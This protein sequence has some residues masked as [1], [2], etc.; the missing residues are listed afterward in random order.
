LAQAL[1]FYSE[2]CLLFF[3]TVKCVPSSIT[4]MMQVL[5]I[6]SLAVVFPH[7]ATAHGAHHFLGTGGR[8]ITPPVDLLLEL[9]SAVGRD[10]RIA[11]ESRVSRLE[12]V[13]GP[14]FASMPKDRDRLDSTGVRYLLHRLFV[15]RHGW[16]IEGLSYNGEAWNSSSPATIFKEHAEDH[17]DLFHNQIKNQGGFSLHQVAVFGAT[18]EVMVHDENVER[19]RAAYYVLGLSPSESIGEDEAVEVIMSY[20]MMY[21]LSANHT[22]LTPTMF[23]RNVAGKIL[24]TY[25][26]WPDTQT[27]VHEVRRAVLED[28]VDDDRTTWVNNLKILEEIGERYGRWQDKDCRDLKQQMMQLESAGNGR[29]LLENLYRAWLNDAGEFSESVPYLRVSGSLDESDPQH[30]SVI[31]PNYLNSPANC[32]ASSKFHSVCC[33]SECEGL[34][35]NLE[36]TLASPDATPARIVELISAL[37]SDSVKA[38]RS[39]PPTLIQRLEEIA[40]HHGGRVPLHGRLFA[41]WMHHAYPHECP[42]P[43]MAGTSRLLTSEQAQKAGFIGDTTKKEARAFI[44]EAEYRKRT[45]ASITTRQTKQ[46]VHVEWHHEEELFVPQFKQTSGSSFAAAFVRGVVLVAV[47]FALVTSSLRMFP[48]TGAKGGCSSDHKYYV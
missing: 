22:S 35:A 48:H 25:P 18:L 12:D 29:V 38:P 8:N 36:N 4:R 37:P 15:Q 28:I 10:H 45:D 44:E 6:G 20:M 24:R 26:M 1:S 34:M 30:L 33:I 19:L 41:Q 14:M 39:L 32:L 2:V 47:L 31:I 11:T 17:H 27:F 46:E 42:Y 13:L 5:I 23:K 9:E 43:H 21:V 40:A 16:F 7:A 3:V